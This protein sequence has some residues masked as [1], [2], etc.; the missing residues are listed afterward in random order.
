MSSYDPR[1]FNKQQEFWSGKPGTDW[2]RTHNTFNAAYWNWQNDTKV[3]LQDLLLSA[4]EYIPRTTT[5][6]EL[7]CNDGFVLKTL[8]DIGFMRLSGLDINEEAIK[9]AK[10]NVPKA[11]FYLQPLEKK[12]DNIH[13]LVF[14]PA[15]L[16]HIHP[17]NLDEVMDTIYMESKRYIF[18]REISSRHPI[19]QGKPGQ[20]WYDYYWTR[21]F[22]DKWIEKFP[23]LKL[24]YYDLI[25]MNSNDTVETEVYLLEKSQIHH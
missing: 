13:D 3:R 21:R 22:K 14:T 4:L 11:K 12:M 9:N 8:E 7:G 18:G 2:A 20:G 23:Q 16:M 6:L 15:V 25:K 10:I 24:Q 17:D 19:A 5:I 1:F